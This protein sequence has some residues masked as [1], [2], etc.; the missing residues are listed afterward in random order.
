MALNVGRLSISL[1]GRG[2]ALSATQRRGLDRRMPTLI[3]TDAR[4]W[5]PKD[6]AAL[7]RCPFVKPPALPEV[8]DKSTICL[9]HLR[10]KGGFAFLGVTF[11]PGEGRNHFVAVL[12]S[13]LAAIDLHDPFAAEELDAESIP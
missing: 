3:G 2:S 8:A 7:S 10:R 4:K 9:L 13:E 11:L 6:H 12:E 1:V 5:R